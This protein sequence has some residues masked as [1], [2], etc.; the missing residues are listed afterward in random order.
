MFSFEDKIDWYL[1]YEDDAY[2]LYKYCVQMKVFEH[3][4]AY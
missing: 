4:P 2:F 3:F 1:V